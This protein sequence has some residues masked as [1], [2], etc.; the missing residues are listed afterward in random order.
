MVNL[1]RENLYEY[2]LLCYGTLAGLN[3]YH[4]NTIS[5][6]YMRMSQIMARTNG[7]QKFQEVNVPGSEYS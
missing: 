6:K 7:E 5:L 3:T 4:I 1:L 2:L